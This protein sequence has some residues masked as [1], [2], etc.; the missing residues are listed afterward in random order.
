MAKTSY[1]PE[2]IKELE[3]YK[4]WQIRDSNIRY[5]EDKRI[6]ACPEIR[7]IIRPL[8]DNISK[9]RKS[10]TPETMQKNFDILLV[11]LMK[12]AYEQ[13]FKPNSRPSLKNQIN[14]IKHKILLDIA[15]GY[16]N[17]AKKKPKK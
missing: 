9:I 13:L 8:E 14:R 5:A 16:A 11:S 10:Q 15:D 3:R 4:E 1:D 12:T 6:A 17:A 2:Y 7:H